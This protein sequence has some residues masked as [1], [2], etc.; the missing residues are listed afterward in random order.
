M[1][2]NFSTARLAELAPELDGPE[3]QALARALGSAQDDETALLRVAV[4]SRLATLCPDDALDGV[5]QWLQIERFDDEPD[6]IYR[7]RLTVAWD[8]WAKAATAQ[9]IIDSLVSYG[10]EDVVVKQDFEGHFA[11]GD[12][13]SSFWVFLLPAPLV[14]PFFLGATLGESVRDVA[15]LIAPFTTP[16]TGGSTASISHIRAVKKQVLK[17]KA[18]Q[19]Y[20]VKITVVFSGAIVGGV[21]STAPFTPGVDAEICAWDIGKLSTENIVT[22]PFTPG[23]YEV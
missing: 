12:W 19:S 1:S 21:N 22:A 9:A 18:A 17:W 7:A 15:P 5:G 10:F 3:G 4:L 20:P 16:C 8:T 14:F 2:G 23:G 6:D 13:Y 11:S